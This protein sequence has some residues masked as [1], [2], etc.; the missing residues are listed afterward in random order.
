LAVAARNDDPDDFDLGSF[1]FDFMQL[2]LIVLS[3]SG[4]RSADGCGH[5]DGALRLAAARVGLPAG[6]LRE[7]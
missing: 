7:R 4:I 6:R 3:G 1:P 2:L 5:M